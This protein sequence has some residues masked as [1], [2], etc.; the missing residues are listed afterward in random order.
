MLLV[1]F[2]LE[3]CFTALSGNTG[4]FATKDFPDNYAENSNCTWEI[5]VPDDHK[6][7]LTIHLLNVSFILFS[8]HPF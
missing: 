1:L 5:S 2:L 3:E 6:I 8:L 7:Q 4:I